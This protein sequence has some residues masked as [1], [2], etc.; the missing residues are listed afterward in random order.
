M[1]IEIL[2]VADLI[3]YENNAKLHPAEQVKQIKTSR[4]NFSEASMKM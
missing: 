4:L 1:K 2:K 3:P